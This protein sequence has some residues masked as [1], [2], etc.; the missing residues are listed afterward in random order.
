MS[1]F[2]F[3]ARP[4]ERSAQTET[5]RCFNNIYGGFSLQALQSVTLSGKL[6]VWGAGYTPLPEGDG[7]KAADVDG[8]D[9]NDGGHDA[10]PQHGVEE[11][12][13]LAGAHRP[14]TVK[15]ISSFVLRKI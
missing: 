8:A 6:Y 9:L 10:E 3:P 13:D 7:D 4:G 15:N 2:C 5:P 11:P 1:N 12:E 14:Q